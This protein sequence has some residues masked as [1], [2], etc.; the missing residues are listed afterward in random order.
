MLTNPYYKGDVVPPSNSLNGMVV[1]TRLSGG[2]G[3][4]NALELELCRLGNK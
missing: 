4:R 1:T 3:G 2:R